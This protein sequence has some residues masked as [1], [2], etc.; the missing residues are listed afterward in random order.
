MSPRSGDTSGRLFDDEQGVSRAVALAI[1]AIVI[2]GGL[3]LFLIAGSALFFAVSSPE[4]TPTATASPIAA[5][6][7]ATP[8]ARPGEGVTVEVVEVVD[9]DTIDVRF[10]NGTT[11]TVRLLG[12]DSPEVYSEVDPSE[13]EGVPSS[14]A[15]RECLADYGDRASNYTRTR[16]AGATV[17]LRFDDRADRRG[18]YGRLL[19]YVIVDG[20]N[21][22]YRLVVEGYA[23]VYDSTFEQSARFYSAE[24]TSQESQTGLWEC[25]SVATATQ[26]PT[27]SGA[28]GG[29]LVVATIH[30]DAEGNDHENLN[31]EYVTFRNEGD[32]E[33]DLSG[34]TVEDE[35]DHTYE[36]PPGFTL[37]PGDEVTLYTGSG[38]DSD[39]ELYW[40]MDSAVWNNGGDTIY[41]YGSNGETRIERTYD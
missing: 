10:R 12:V 1:V 23:R 32:S 35:A 25:R 4:P 26:V 13:F 20:E 34:W 36:F 41:V 6:S 11:D 7:S 14:E 8:T 16:L 38:D 3:M 40:E 19:A 9:G 24:E 39:S 22:N 31:D 29:D 15:G 33:M 27:P 17:Q 30:E 21:F 18:G 5:G 28:G 37:G 2:L